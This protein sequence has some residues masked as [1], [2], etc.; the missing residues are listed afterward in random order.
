MSEAD[1]AGTVV[2]TD[3]LRLSR[4]RHEVLAGLDIEVRAGEWVAVIGPNGAG[5]TTLL[6]V[7]GGLLGRRG[8]DAVVSGGLDVVGLDPRS[9]PR[10]AI[11]RQVA[12]VPQRPVV[13]PGAS[14]ADLV[15]L[16]RTPHLGPWGVETRTDHRVV[17][18]ALGRL[19]LAGF[20]HREA[21][22]LSGGEL[23]RVILARALVQQ[24]RLLL[25]D[26]PTSALDIGYQQSVLDLVDRLRVEDGLTVVAAMHDL[27]LAGQYADRLVLL[28]QGL[29]VA[30]GPPCHVLTVEFLVKVYGARI[31][32][33]ETVDG[34]VVVPVRREW[35]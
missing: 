28:D 2:R 17:G 22:T 3:R 30:E 13:P 29:V 25:L 14:V 5:K 31:R 15:L 23:Q 27:T 4:G 35:E 20:A 24:P 7:L 32:V 18:V 26:E 11:A 1:A 34:P 33:L 12:L 10:R 8:G 21:A 19:G 6:Q 16:G 9:A